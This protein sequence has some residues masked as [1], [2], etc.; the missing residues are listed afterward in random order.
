MHRRTFL[1]A[2]AASA[3]LIA[4]CLAR[5]SGSSAGRRASIAETDAVPD[6]P[7]RPSVAVVAPGAT[8]DS[9]PRLRAR[10]T[11][12]ADYRVEV[13]EERAVVF[14]FVYSTDRPGVVL[15]PE[16]ADQYPAVESGCWRL[17]EPVAVAEYY[18]V[19]ALDPGESAE[20][21]LGVWGD[22][23]GSD[24]LPTG[25]FRF[26]TTYEVGRDRTEGIDDLEERGEWGF[27]LE[28]E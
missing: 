10:V 9:P 24:C 23:D 5:P 17:A 7:V 12:E 14:A 21:T 16:P 15:L 6:L 22:P 4:G 27:V 11:N 18:G 1:R 25:R 3:P 2:G 8:D 19:T 13:G 26:T 28:I 20:R